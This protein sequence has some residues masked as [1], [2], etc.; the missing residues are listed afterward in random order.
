MSD[1]LQTSF[2]DGRISYARNGALYR[3]QVVWF[4]VDAR[5]LADTQIA[6]ARQ[7]VRSRLHTTGGGRS[8]FRLIANGSAA[9]AFARLAVARGH[10]RYQQVIDFYAVPAR[11]RIP[12]VGGDAYSYE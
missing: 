6:L 9:L 4:G 1:I 11:D 7:G 10:D 8:S 12:P 3:V 2:E 5:S